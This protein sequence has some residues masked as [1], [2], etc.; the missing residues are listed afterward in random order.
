M[1]EKEAWRNAIS[2]S[3]DNS[4]DRLMMLFNNDIARWIDRGSPY[5]IRFYGFDEMDDMDWF[6]YEDIL[7]ADPDTKEDLDVM[8]AAEY[9]VIKMKS[10]K[11]RRN[12]IRM[13]YK[14]TKE[15]E[16]FDTKIDIRYGRQFSIT[17]KDKEIPEIKAKVD[18][19]KKVNQQ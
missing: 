10:L 7:V 1:D 6:D 4:F 16:G 17:P 2:T 12:F 9:T 13:A 15:I 14:A 11:T 3:V 8:Q 19:L 18:M 5:E